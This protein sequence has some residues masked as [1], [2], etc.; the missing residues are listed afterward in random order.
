MDAAVVIFF[1]IL[2]VSHSF[3]LMVMD[4]GKSVLRSGTILTNARQR[5]EERYSSTITYERPVLELVLQASSLLP[6]TSNG[7]AFAAELSGTQGRY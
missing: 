4:H 3:K 6:K 7:N 2:V 5:D 1:E